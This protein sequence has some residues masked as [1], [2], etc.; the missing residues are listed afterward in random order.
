MKKIHYIDDDAENVFGYYE[1]LTRDELKAMTVNG[2]DT[3]C[4][5]YVKK[6]DEDGVLTSA[7]VKYLEGAIAGLDIYAASYGAS[8]FSEKGGMYENEESC[9]FC[10]A[11]L[12][13]QG[14]VEA[15]KRLKKAYKSH[16]S[17]IDKCDRKI[18]ETKL[19]NLTVSISAAHYDGLV[20]M[21]TPASKNKTDDYKSANVVNVATVKNGVRSTYEPLYTSYCRDKYPDRTTARLIEHLTD[22]LKDAALK[23][24]LK[25]FDVYRLTKLV[26]HYGESESTRYETAAV[27]ETADTDIKVTVSDERLNAEPYV[28]PACGAPIENGVCTA[29]GKSFNASDT[30]SGKIV[31]QRAKD[32]EALLCTQCRAPVTLD[33]SGKSAVCPYCGTTFI[34][35]GN[36]LTGS[37]GGLDFKSIR[38]DMPQDAELPEVKFIRADIMNNKIS[39]VMP[40]SFKVMSE[41]HRRIKYPVNPP[42]YVYTTPD[43][44]VNLCL[45]ATGIPLEDKN[46]P[47]IGRQILASLKGL[48]KDA[49]YGE[50]KELTVAGGKHVFFID[51]MTQGFDQSIYNAMFFFEIGG[52]QGTGSW[53]CLGKDRWYWAQI[54][55][56]AVKTMR[57]N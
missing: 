1:A 43:T 18:L 41:E 56:H 8:L 2:D 21:L 14:S 44:C 23:I 42:E 46:V 16:A 24:G 10:Y 49:V 37:V 25:E 15:H 13:Q 36:A 12:E 28:C 39:A 34:V 31:I 7:D 9:I 20:I 11:V 27:N 35:N 6:C 54:F 22:Y 17:L 30:A 52:R 26:Y 40:D 55:E 38:A 19:A 45:S 32:M 4:A 5:F 53:N 33:K 48:R 51:F 3:A 50:A 47:L 29:C 57:F